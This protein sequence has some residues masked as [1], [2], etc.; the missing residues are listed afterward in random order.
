MAMVLVV[1]RRGQGGRC[2]S[3][4]GDD[5]EQKSEEF[6]AQRIHEASWEANPPIHS[7][8]SLF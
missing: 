8:G 1:M 5:A 2:E 6:G 7:G 3:R 4:E